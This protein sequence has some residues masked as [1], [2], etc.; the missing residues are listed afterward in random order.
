MEVEETFYLL[1]SAHD[2][3]ERNVECPK[4]DAKTKN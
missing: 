1:R 3:Y 4:Q 2:G